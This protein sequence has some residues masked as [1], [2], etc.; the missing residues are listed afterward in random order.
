MAVEMAH[1]RESALPEK[2]GGL[3][4]RTFSRSLEYLAIVALAGAAVAL[5]AFFV[6]RE[7]HRTPALFTGR[8][9]PTCR[10]AGIADGSTRQGTCTTSHA[11]I[12]V[13]NQ[14]P[15]VTMPGLAARA[16]SATVTE[17]STASGRARHRIRVSV[18]FALRNTGSA[19]LFASGR[20]PQ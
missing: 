12:T 8:H 11:L 17:A 9:F 2:R 14:G 5:V 3:L 4:G 16:S 19:S 1:S 6:H 7:Q 15:L 18:G 20:D 13:G 10:D